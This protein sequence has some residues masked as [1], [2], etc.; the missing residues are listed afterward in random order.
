LDCW[1]SCGEEILHNTSDAQSGNINVRKDHN[2]FATINVS[3]ELEE[4]IVFEEDDD[5][6]DDEDG[7][8]ETCR[9]GDDPQSNYAM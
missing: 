9:E 1:L 7:V 4:P 3:I 8:A 5:T 6:F 2:K